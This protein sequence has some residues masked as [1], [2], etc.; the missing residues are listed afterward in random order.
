MVERLSG[1][2]DSVPEVLSVGGEHAIPWL[3]A[4]AELERAELLDALFRLHYVALLRLTVVMLGSREAAEDAI[5]DTFVSLH[6]HA[7]SLR[8]PGRPKRTSAPRCST[9]VDPGCGV[10]SPTQRARGPAAHTRSPGESGGH[11]S[12]SRRG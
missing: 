10:R 6:R 4:T 5:Q 9:V 11:D 1:M 2:T 8:A 12:E 7:R 3:Q